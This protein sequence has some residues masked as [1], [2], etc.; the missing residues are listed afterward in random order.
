MASFH[1]NFRL[2]NCAAADASGR[3]RQCVGTS[4]ARLS[5]FVR[6]WRWRARPL[7]PR[8]A[9]ELHERR[10][11]NAVHDDRGGD[12]R[13]NRGKQV[14]RRPTAIAQS[15]PRK[16]RVIHRA[17]A[18]DAEPGQQAARC[19]VCGIRRACLST[20]PAAGS[21]RTAAPRAAKPGHRPVAGGNHRAHQQDDGHLDDAFELLVDV[22]HA[23]RQRRFVGLRRELA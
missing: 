12:H 9:V 6:Q 18:A 3:D 7:R 23:G 15:C 11:R 20:P 21:R 10:R 13:E 8:R 4:T 1:A 16:N 2:L 14:L 5:S 22:Q 19:A 17:D